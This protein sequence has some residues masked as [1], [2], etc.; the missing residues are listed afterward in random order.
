MAGAVT[1]TRPIS[2]ASS[3]ADAELT[4]QVLQ[5]LAQQ[6]K[7]LSPTYLYDARGSALF[8]LICRQPE[9]Y[10][11]RTELAIMRRYGAEIAQ[12]IGSRALLLE[13]GSGASL[14]TRILLDRL[15]DLAAYVPV[16]IS[17]SSLGAATRSIRES[18]PTLEVLPVEADF[19]RPFA[20]PSARA[21]AARTI[22]Y[23]PGSTI[24]N[25][26]AGPAVELLALARSLAGPNGALIIGIDLVKDRELLLRAYDD[27][28][29]VTAAF[30][31]NILERLN[32]ELGADFDAR[33]FRHAA[34]WN[35]A[36]SRIEMHLESLLSQSVQ[37]GGEAIDFA[38][39]EPIITEH[40]HK[41]T[42]RSFGA[43][44]ARA[45]WRV[46]ASWSDERRFFSVLYLESR[47]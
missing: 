11:T 12:R 43:L 32:R 14:K 10:L 42:R 38:V 1:R 20:L 6:P 34:V 3:A 40:C 5:G 15:P 22:V 24:G 28:A 26:D 21:E 37:L 19:T 31:L 36:A 2:R 8:E 46:R 9:Y 30:N 33:S 16:D 35:A 18:Y 7:R 4:A 27:A 17:R 44:A 13:L 25:F 45:G 47:G 41:Y 23:F 29:G 39:G